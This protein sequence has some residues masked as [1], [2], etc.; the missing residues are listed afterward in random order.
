MQN[1]NLSSIKKQ[2]EEGLLPYPVFAAIDGDLQP[3]WRKRKTQKSWFEFTPHH[4]GYPALGAFVPI[5]QFGSRFENGTLVRSE[6]ERDLTY[7]RGLWG[8]ALADNEEIKKYIWDMLKDLRQQLKQK[9]ART[10]TCMDSPEIQVDEVLLDLMMAYVKD[11]NDPS[12]KDKLRTLQQVLSAE[13]ADESGEQKYIWLAEIVQIWDE[14]SPK[15]KEQFLEYLLYCFMRPREFYEDTSYSLMNLIRGFLQD[16]FTFLSKTGMCFWRW[17]WGTVYNFLYKHGNITDEAMKSREF[18]HLVDAG[19]AINTP[20]PLVL[21]PAR[22][23]HLILS[24]D[25]SAGDPLEF[26][27][28]IFLFPIEGPYHLLKVIFGDEFFSSS[29]LDNLT[30]ASKLLGFAHDWQLD[31]GPALGRMFG[32]V[33]LCVFV[34][35]CAYDIETWRN[36]YDTMKLSDSYTP[37]LVTDLLRVSK[38][39]VQMNKDNILNEMRKVAAK[40]GNFPG[41][42]EEDCW[43]DTVQYVQSSRT[44]EIKV[45]NNTDI[46]FREPLYYLQSGHVLV[47]PPPLL[48]P[49]STINC[50]FVKKSS[51]FQ[52]TVGILVYQGPSVHFALLFSVPFNY[53]LHRIEFALAII[54]EP[55]SRDLQTVFDDIIQG[56]ES[57]EERPLGQDEIDEL[58]EAFQEFDKDR[59]GFISYKDLG[60]LMR[61]MGYMPTEM[62]LTEL[63][64]QIR[65]NLGGRV[66][67]EDFVELMTPKLLAETAGVIGVQ[68][69]RDAFKEFDANGDG[70]ITLAELQQ[71]MQRLLGEKLTPREISEVVQE[72][73]VNGDGTVDFEGLWTIQTLGPGAPGSVKDYYPPTMDAIIKKL[74]IEVTS[75]NSL[76]KEWYPSL[77]G[78]GNIAEEQTGRIKE[79]EA[80]EMC[81][82][83]LSSRHDLSIAH[84]NLQ[85]LWFSEQDL[86]RIKPVKTLS[87]G[88]AVS[89]ATADLSVPSYHN[90][91][92]ARPD[93]SVVLA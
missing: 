37:D 26:F 35:A 5:T 16:V 42:S 87:I 28:G 14:I 15:E 46:T 70:E 23:A 12:I 72:A 8:S 7:L 36:K 79:L 74:E 93:L 21:L 76:E 64:Q 3:E 30:N 81:S 19:L 75:G 24:F 27:K 22:E 55:V 91:L 44:V 57:S 51:S 62:E 77:Q 56:K 31:L 45:S 49:E 53:A 25:F 52:G 34:F 6:P 1:S 59:D 80:G 71:A 32:T 17:E 63:G 78:L 82:E 4:A 10:A 33:L 41:V 18:L 11:Q 68:E 85:Q 65:M 43:G 61:T 58:R 38:E 73:D 66:D 48:S 9:E 83:M 84:M 60:N 40:H 47:D 50:S 89:I 69:M 20:Y 88:L 90:G 13:R 29:V 39:N 92:N 67:F 86:S 54:T 2:V